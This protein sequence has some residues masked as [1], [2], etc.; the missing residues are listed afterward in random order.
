MHAYERVPIDR[1]VWKY[2]I[3]RSHI[4]RSTLQRIQRL[5]CQYIA[6]NVRGFACRRRTQRSAEAD[7]NEDRA[8]MRFEF[9]EA[10]LRVAITMRD[11]D[12][13]GEV[14]PAEKVNT[15][16]DIATLLSMTKEC[17]GL[18]KQTTNRL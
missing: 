14:A 5:R 16:L 15:A 6:L 13:E 3:T 18:N 8:L 1:H 2:L 17:L 4:Q 10:L 12:G 11:N 7:V 9:I